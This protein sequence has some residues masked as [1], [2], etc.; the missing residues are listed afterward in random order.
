MNVSLLC[1]WIGAPLLVACVVA[2]VN[3][4]RATGRRYGRPLRRALAPGETPAGVRRDDRV[5]RALVLGQVVGAV[6][7]VLGVVIS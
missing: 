4:S 7:L 2:E 1:F 6:V 3:R 5:T